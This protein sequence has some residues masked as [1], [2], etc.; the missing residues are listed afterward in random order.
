MVFTI[1]RL[2]ARRAATKSPIRGQASVLG[3]RPGARRDNL[4]CGMLLFGGHDFSRAVEPSGTGAKDSLRHDS[5]IWLRQGSV[6][7]IQRV[8]RNQLHLECD[9]PRIH[10]PL[11]PCSEPTPS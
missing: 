3:T 10:V 2:A 6:E 8:W 1:A 11:F 7:Y 9:D 5:Q 4:P